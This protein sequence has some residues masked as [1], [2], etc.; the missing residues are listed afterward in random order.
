MEFI[1]ATKSLKDAQ[2]F[3]N[4]LLN[5]LHKEMNAAEEDTFDLMRIDE[6]GTTYQVLPCYI[7]SI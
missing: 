6:S 5:S 3:I 7:P 1:S 2:I 4:Q